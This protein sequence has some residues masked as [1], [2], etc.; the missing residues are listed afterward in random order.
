[1]SALRRAFPA[2]LLFLLLL[3]LWAGAV[4]AGNAL[5]ALPDAALL[6]YHTHSFSHTQLLQIEKSEG[7]NERAL[8]FS[9]FTQLDAQ[10]VESKLYRRTVQ[11]DVLL[12]YGDLRR[13][14]RAVPEM[15]FVSSA[16]ET[17]CAVDRDTAFRLWGSAQVLGETLLFEGREYTVRAV[18]DAPEGT[19]ALP[20]PTEGHGLS[21]LAV[22]T[23]EGRDAR[24][25]AEEFYRRH[26][27]PAPDAL[28][29]GGWYGPVSRC[30]ILLPALPLLAALLWG[31]LRELWGMRRT[32]VLCALWCLAA[33]VL[34]WGLFHFSGF[35][36]SLPP[37]LVPT[38]W[39]DFE[40]WRRL[41]EGWGENLQNALL[42]PVLA[43]DRL[44][45]SALLRLLSCSF[46]AA[47]D[48]IGMM[49]LYY[50]YKKGR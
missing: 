26:G 41:L 47:A 49:I 27:L 18:F 39:S 15:E 22:D 14:L 28:T 45:G 3:P 5:R 12:F 10:P 37:G 25:Q 2:L 7:E 23:P 9:A 43:P 24:Q 1:V 46:F 16:D 29:T 4:T 44:V 42:T 38:R 40:F 36:L 34:F 33:A 32:P 35:R 50:K 13:I 19:V 21:V 17:G 11:A 48:V 30:L 8:P 31:I 6:R 20:V